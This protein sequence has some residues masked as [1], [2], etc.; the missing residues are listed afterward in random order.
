MNGAKSMWN[1]GQQTAPGNSINGNVELL[2][3]MTSGFVWWIYITG[4]TQYEK[5]N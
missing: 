4:I 5:V 3:K 2:W 1:T